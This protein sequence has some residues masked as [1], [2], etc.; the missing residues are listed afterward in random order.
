ML[1][2][3]FFLSFFLPPSLSPPPSLLPLPITEAVGPLEEYLKD[4]QQ[5]DQQQQQQQQ[6]QQLHND[7]TYLKLTEALLH[8]SSCSSSA[9]SPESSP[10]RFCLNPLTLSFSLSLYNLPR[11]VWFYLVLFYFISFHFIYFFL[12]ISPFLIPLPTLPS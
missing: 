7:L 3:S 4:Q 10:H 12:C 5:L 2:S 6:Q 11:F 8:L 9:I 1:T